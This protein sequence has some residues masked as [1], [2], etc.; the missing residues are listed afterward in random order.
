MTGE[1]RAT[2]NRTDVHLWIAPSTGPSGEPRRLREYAADLS[3][4][5]RHR[6][7]RF[8][9]LHDRAQFV[10]A[11]SL[12]RRCLSQYAD[13]A[14]SEWEFEFNSFGKP[15]VHRRLGVDLDFN[16]SHSR[17]MCMLGVTRERPIGVD[18]EKRDARISLPDLLHQVLSEAELEELRHLPARAWKSRFLDVWVFKEAYA[19][20]RGQGISLPLRDISFLFAGGPQP[21][22]TLKPSLGDRPDDWLYDFVRVPADFHAAV[23][24]GRRGDERLRLVLREP[25][26]Y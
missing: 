24:I 10:T 11:R 6:A 1:S 19:K 2:L 15:A 17:G 12:L 9:F 23:C 4:E 21:R 3:P 13:I 22:L 20:A 25:P 18:V 7:D 16:L 5:E 26:R 8:Y 14:P